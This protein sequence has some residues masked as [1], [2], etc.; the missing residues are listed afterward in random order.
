ME[1]L[2]NLRWSVRKEPTLPYYTTNSPYSEDNQTEK[3]KKDITASDHLKK[4]FLA[5]K[6]FFTSTHVQ[7]KW[8]LEN[9]VP[10]QRPTASALRSSS[11][12]TSLPD[13]F[14]EPIRFPV[15]RVF[16]AITRKDD[17]LGRPVGSVVAAAIMVAMMCFLF[18][19]KF[20]GIY[21]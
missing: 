6:P 10:G 2:K 18:A 3:E 21:T 15:R 8:T 1:S 19:L 13:G 5:I 7:E 20:F 14:L 17:H 16:R 12:T 11:R 9:Q 4:P